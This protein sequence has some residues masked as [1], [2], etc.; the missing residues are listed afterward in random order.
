VIGDVMIDQWIYLKTNRKSPEAEVNILNE[1]RKYSAPGGAANVIRHLENMSDVSH[2][3]IGLQGNDGASEELAELVK[4]LK[5]RVD[6]VTDSS[7]KTSLKIRY[8]VDNTPVF[9]VDYEDSH[10]QSVET[11]A[12]IKALIEKR[13]S[14][15]DMVLFS[16]Y[17]KGLITSSLVSYTIGLGRERCVPVLAD[18]GLGRLNRFAGCDV[19]K[20]NNR[21]WKVYI[22]QIGSESKAISKLFSAGTKHIFVT[23]G[24]QG[25][26][27]ISHDFDIV[28]PIQDDIKHPDVTGAGDS[29][30][31]ALC[32]L[33]QTNSDSKILLSALNQVGA[34][35]V[36]RERTE[37]PSRS[38]FKGLDQSLT[39][40]DSAQ[41]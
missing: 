3:L 4:D 25:I 40:R 6:L 13:V 30:A 21:E 7:R 5:S 20:P 8:L 18:P 12:K 19:I 29:I 9:R 39:T 14:S 27:M 1:T 38:V 28:E 22:D 2:G 34:S 16:D 32:L 36:S 41:K 24:N 31:A 11:E 35:A 26:R 37:L 33:Y 10:D 15:N 17:G 23:M